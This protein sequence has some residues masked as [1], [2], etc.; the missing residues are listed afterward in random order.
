MTNAAVPALLLQPELAKEW[1]PK[2][3]SRDYDKRFKPA[4]RQD[5]ASPSA[6]A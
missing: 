5:A 2:I 1:L 3:L 6:W 4:V